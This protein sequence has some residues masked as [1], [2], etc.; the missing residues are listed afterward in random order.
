MR[1]SRQ[2]ILDTFRAC[3]AKIGKA[4]GRELFEKLT[5]I[6]GSEV[7]YYWPRHSALVEEAGGEPNRLRSRLPDELVFNDYARVCL[8]LGKIPSLA[9]LNIAQ[10]E[11]GAKTHTV[12]TRFSGG[13]GEFR[14]RFRKWLE[15]AP[16]ELKPILQFEG[17]DTVR[18]GA[19]RVDGVAVAQAQP[20]LHPFLPAGLQYLETLARGQRPPFDSSDTAVS[21]LFER[22]V[23]DA[24]RCL[25]FEV[26]DL[27]QG[28]GRKPD[29]LAVAGRERF[30]VIIDAKSRSGSY[31]L[32]TEDRKFLEYAR[33][34]GA[35]LQ[36]RETE[37]VYL[38]IVASSFNVSDADKLAAY[39]T[40]SPIR[41]MTMVTAGALIR[42]V[43]SNIRERFK[44]T[45]A[46]FERDLFRQRMIA[47]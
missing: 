25:G 24:F 2:E 32:G 40:D 1:R 43:E 17:W 22:R 47:S 41:S 6:K 9:E 13:L 42:I 20:T 31:V 30:A 27:G 34:Q 45:L 14:D 39:V 46:D 18:G 29:A 36:R 19:R 7:A 3:Q 23:A 16:V 5:G 10:R 11:L 8:H 4:P 33:G 26:T 35:E 44:F 28:T 37:R 38:A 15:V 21:T 12:D